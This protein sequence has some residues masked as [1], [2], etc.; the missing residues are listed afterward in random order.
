MW[1]GGEGV[2]GVGRCSAAADGTNSTDSLLT[3]DS[4]DK[5]FSEKEKTNVRIQLA[6]TESTSKFCYIMLLHARVVLNV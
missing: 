1:G 5:C 3:H 6:F 2:E 4:G